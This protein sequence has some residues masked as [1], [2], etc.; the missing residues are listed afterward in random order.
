M[1]ERHQDYQ[2]SFPTVPP[3]GLQNVPLQLDSDAPFLLRLVKTRNLAGNGF[4]FRTARDAYQSSQLR[5]D[6]LDNGL[7]VLTPGQGVIIYPEEVYPVNGTIVVDVGNAT[8]APLSN[9]RVL[10]RGSKIYQD[11]ALAVSTYPARLSDLPYTYPVVIANVPVTGSSKR[12]PGLNCAALLT[13]ILSIKADGRADFVVRYLAADPFKLRIDGGVNPPPQQFTE[14]YVQL[15]D[16]SRKYYS[17]EP[18]HIDD[19]FGRGSPLAA[20]STP[21]RFL[22]GLLTPEIYLPNQGALYFDV[23]R[24]DS[25]LLNQFPV[26]IHFRFQGA[27]VIPR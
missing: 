6:Y 18:I 23:Y 21:N 1:I 24:D 4:R 13:N 26:D 10:F 17:N 25:A 5:T 9:V 20:S 12:V 16:E 3:G 15:M 2:L 19:L 8:Q 11:A 7:G 27:R 14:V 22:P